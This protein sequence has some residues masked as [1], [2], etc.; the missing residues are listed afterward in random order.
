VATKKQTRTP[1][2][3]MGPKHP[4]KKEVLPEMPAV[5]GRNEVSNRQRSSKQR[6]IAKEGSGHAKKDPGRWGKSNLLRREKP[7]G[8]SRIGG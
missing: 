2:G 8:P 1:T 3:N 4:Q 7:Q 6:W 5:F